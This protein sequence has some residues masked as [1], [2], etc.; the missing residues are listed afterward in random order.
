MFCIWHEKLS[1]GDFMMPVDRN[2]Q[3]K[4]LDKQN[5]CT[6]QPLTE[7]ER[8]SCTRVTGSCG[9]TSFSSSSGRGTKHCGRQCGWQ[10]WDKQTYP[11]V[12]NIC[13]FKSGKLLCFCSSLLW[14]QTPFPTSTACLPLPSATTAS[15]ASSQFMV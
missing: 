1:W 7:R 4:L 2:T 3:T 8:C 6:K 5:F 15:T 13:T 14:T 12:L 11:L 10:S 9:V